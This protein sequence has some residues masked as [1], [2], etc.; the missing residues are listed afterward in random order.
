MV[1]AAEGAG[2]GS[3]PSAQGPGVTIGTLSRTD[4]DFGQCR[5]ELERALRSRV[6]LC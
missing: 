2:E 1:R 4:C 3:R 5:R 6:D